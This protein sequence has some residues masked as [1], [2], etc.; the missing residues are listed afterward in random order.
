MASGIDCW[1]NRLAYHLASAAMRIATPRYRAM[2]HGA[3]RYGL[4]AAARDEEEERE[5]PPDLIHQLFCVRQAQ[6]Q[7]EDKHDW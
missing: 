1:R 5:L 7:G 4:N 3:W 6:L 2:A